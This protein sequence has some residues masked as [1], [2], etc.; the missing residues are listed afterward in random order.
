MVLFFRPYG[1]LFVQFGQ[2]VGPTLGGARGLRIKASA[3]QAFLV[4]KYHPLAIMGSEF[5]YHLPKE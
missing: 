3:E 2:K 4:S 5:I 1:G